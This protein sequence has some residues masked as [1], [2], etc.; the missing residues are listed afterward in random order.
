MFVCVQW[1]GRVSHADAEEYRQP[2]C[3]GFTGRCFW[4]FVCLF[5]APPALF[6][7]PV[8]LLF[9]FFFFNTL[10]IKCFI[11]ADSLNKSICPGFLLAPN[12]WANE[13]GA[14]PV[15]V[16]E[17]FSIHIYALSSISHDNQHSLSPPCC[18]DNR[19]V[20]W[21]SLQLHYP[22]WCQEDKSLSHQPFAVSVPLNELINWGD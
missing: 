3:P 13:R 16:A 17:L 9:S 18:R 19:C 10:M 12:Q 14:P 20:C 6:F 2:Q 21:S 8:Q 22:T 5:K 1:S 4:P 7:P 11:T 15:N